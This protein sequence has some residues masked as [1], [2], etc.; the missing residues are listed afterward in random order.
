[1]FRKV[2]AI[3]AFT[4]LLGLHH[5]C[6]YTSAVC[7]QHG[8]MHLLMYMSAVCIQYGYVH[9]CVY[10]SVV[11]VKHVYMHP[12]VYISVVCAHPV[13]IHA[14]TIVRVCSMYLIPTY[15]CT[16][17]WHTESPSYA[18]SKGD[19]YQLEIK[20]LYADGFENQRGRILHHH[21]PCFLILV[22]NPVSHP[23]T[24]RHSYYVHLFYLFPW[25]WRI[26]LLSLLSP[27]ILLAVLRQHAERHDY[28][29]L[30][31]DS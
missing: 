24:T 6:M 21:V 23:L 4:M 22:L 9:P 26:C 11:C 14:P 15:K 13:Y 25:V 30:D 7:A 29:L 28:C 10:T 27:V 18:T 16:G 5:S 3:N 12:L 2:I 1:M 8:Y 19:F 17:W 31:S 20:V